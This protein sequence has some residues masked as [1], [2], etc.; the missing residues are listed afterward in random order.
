MYVTGKNIYEAQQV[1]NLFIDTNLNNES[2]CQ[3]NH[4]FRPSETDRGFYILY[5]MLP[6]AL[7]NGA[8]AESERSDYPD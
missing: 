7:V 1:P 6:P 3:D 4:N 8:T 2:N 5:I